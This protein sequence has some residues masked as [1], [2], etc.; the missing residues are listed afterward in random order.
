MEIP[1]TQA[2]AELAELVS[3]VAYAGERVT[4]TRHGK[5]LAALVPISDLERLEALDSAPASGRHDFGFTREPAAGERPAHPH[6]V[7]AKAPPTPGDRTPRT[8]LT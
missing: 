6:Q 2:R 5:S 3:Q 7:A 1:V 8:T 4:L